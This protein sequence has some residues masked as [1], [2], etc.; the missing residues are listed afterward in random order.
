MFRPIYKKKERIKSKFYYSNISTKESKCEIQ[1]NNVIKKKRKSFKYPFNKTLHVTLLSYALL[2]LFW[3]KNS[4]FGCKIVKWTAPS[5]FDRFAIFNV[6][7]F[8]HL[9]HWT[10]RKRQSEKLT[11]FLINISLSSSANSILFKLI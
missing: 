7:S 2:I 4:F 5:T 1:N 11:K 8:T 3:R 9:L 6:N 10:L